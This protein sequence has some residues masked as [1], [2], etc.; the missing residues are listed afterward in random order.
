MTNA[1][2]AA[3]V[4]ALLVADTNLTV[5]DGKVPVNPVDGK[6]PARPYVVMWSPPVPHSIIDNLSGRSGWQ[7]QIVTV[8]CVGDTAGSV[9]IVAR[10]VRDAVLDVVPVVTGRVSLPIR[11]DGAPTPTQADN[12]IQPPVMYSVLRWACSSTPS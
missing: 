2:A 3:A 12:D 11:M 1:D 10:R 6:L 8:T 9:A 7:E 4:L 5:F